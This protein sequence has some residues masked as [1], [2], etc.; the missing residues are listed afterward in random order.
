[1]GE[2]GLLKEVVAE[3][4]AS[5]FSILK[6]DYKKQKQNPFPNINLLLSIFQNLLFVCRKQKKNEKGKRRNKPNKKK[7]QAFS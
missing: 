3:R 1:M 5:S 4:G 2:L 6:T 7:T